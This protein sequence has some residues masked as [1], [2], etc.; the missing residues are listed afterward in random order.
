M[1]ETPP[2]PASNQPRNCGLAI[3]SLL[4]GI[5]GIVLS[6]I[7]IGLLLAIPAVICGHMAY[8]RVSRSSGALTGHG[9]AL[10]GLITGYL[11]IAMIP[12]IAMLAAIAIP[13]F[14]K[15][16]NTAQMNAC[17]NTLR[18]IAGAKHAWALEQNKNDGDAI[19]AADIS[20]FLRPG[21]LQCP[22]GGVYQI[23]PVGEDPTCSILGHELPAEKSP[24]TKPQ[25][26]TRL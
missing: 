16:R 22:K 3:W 14:V 20:V 24:V 15:A 12:I 4:L 18:Q 21:T 9:L 6:P 7:L 8:G 10:G 13:N 1:N 19:T 5:F 25:R 23:N 17:I 2:L 11:S 26:G